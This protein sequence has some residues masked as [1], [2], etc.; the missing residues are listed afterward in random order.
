MNDCLFKPISLTA[1]ERQLAQISP[2]S[3]GLILDL[4][5]FEALTGGDPQM[6]RRLLEELLSSSRRDRQELLAL[7]AAQASS[8]DI[9][10]QAHKI[11]GAARIV[12]ARTLA[13]QCESLEQVCAQD[14]DRPLIDTQVKAL[15]KLMLELERLLQVQLQELESQ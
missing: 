13:S 8:R 15:E 1:L 2:R 7:I 12:Q 11:K 10:E 4:G 6:S 3:A 5:N 14:A 9:S